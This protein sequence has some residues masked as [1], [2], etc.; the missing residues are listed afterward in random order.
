MD[1]STAIV[2]VYSALAGLVSVFG[3]H[4]AWLL[5]RFRWAEREPLPELDDAHAPHVTLQL[6]LYNERT[7][8]ARLI[9]AAGALDYPRDKLEIQVLDDSSDETRALVD[10][11]V[12]RLRELGLDAK[13]VRREERT[14]FK[15]GALAH[16]LES[17][18]GEFIGVFDADFAPRA[19]FLRRVMGAFADPGIDLVQARWEHLNRDASSFTRA[20]AVLLDGHFVIT[21]KVRFDRGL[22][23]HF[24]GTAGVWRR[25]A[26]ERAGG[27]QHD[28]LTEDLDLSYRAQLAGSRLRYAAH[29]AA[30]AELPA[31][32]AAFKSQQ[33]RWARGTVQTARKLLGRIL[34]APLP[35]RVKLEAALHFSAHSGHPI[36]LAL[37]LLFPLSV[38]AASS[39]PYGWYAVL[40]GLCTPAV[41]L[42]YARAQR[43]LGRTWL[44]RTRDCVLAVVL[45]LGMSASL[46][47]A[48]LAGLRRSTGEFV[49]TPKR[50]DGARRAYA[51]RR[52]AW[53]GVE[54]AFA[55]WALFGVV[56]ALRVGAWAAAGF[57]ALY[58]AGFA[59]VGCLSF[60]HARRERLADGEPSASVNSVET[61]PA[62]ESRKPLAR[63]RPRARAS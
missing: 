34:R 43:A 30:P 5:A 39:V 8:A 4:R 41:A 53:P 29:V 50:G 58:V 45:G 59:W 12:A 63:P 15:A 32:I 33:A 40:I 7:V 31:D 9:R 20:Q 11:E 52:V 22:F 23:L 61:S 21:H 10:L 18:K 24:N 13:A 37:V 62:R 17:A 14:G 42:F 60:V 44:E 28:T 2:G 1:T 16:G 46:A 57:A 27:W 48:A 19:D 25:S 3:A 35:W 6:P 55:A 54:L 56:Q 38:G 26:I 36:V 49:R 47:H 51:A